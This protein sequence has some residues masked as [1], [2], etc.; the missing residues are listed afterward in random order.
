[1]TLDRYRRPR[2]I[3]L[4][5]TA[6]AY[7]AA[8]AMAEHAIGAVL[9]SQGHEIVG[10]VTDRD[11]V[12]EIVAADLD[13]YSTPLSDVMSHDVVT[14]DIGASLAEVTRLMRL[15]ACR[16]IPITEDGRPVG[17]V[18]LDDLLADGEFAQATRLVVAAQL[19]EA[20][21]AARAPLPPR[22]IG[23]RTAASCLEGPR[24]D[25]EEDLF[26]RASY[27]RSA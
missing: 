27:R 18:T 6:T 2:M 14:L 10:I 23:V 25:G 22:P 24:A 7:E 8:R 20:S 15:H 3:V 19:D 16:R 5:P 26:P 9:V 1:M 12:L 21:G 11:L 4:P 13:P 17:L